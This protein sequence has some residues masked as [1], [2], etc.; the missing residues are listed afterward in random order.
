MH[1]SFGRVLLGCTQRRISSR[2]QTWLSTRQHNQVR[3][4]GPPAQAHS[5]PRTSLDPWK[6]RPVRQ[7]ASLLQDLELACLENPWC[8][9]CPSSLSTRKGIATGEAL[10]SHD[11]AF[12]QFSTQTG[13]DE[14]A[15]AGLNSVW[16]H[17]SLD[18]NQYGLMKRGCLTLW[19]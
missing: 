3:W 8:F 17:T 13:K 16:T 2:D 1:L 4:R 7:L 19:G 10:S 15:R 9:R 5:R 11:P 12:V 6:S 18:W 14:V